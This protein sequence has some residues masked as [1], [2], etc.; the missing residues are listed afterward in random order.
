MILL[1]I[2]VLLLYLRGDKSFKEV[3]SFIVVP[4]LMFGFLSIRFVIVWVRLVMTLCLSAKA[5]SDYSLFTSFNLTKYSFLYS[6]N[7]AYSDLILD[8]KS[9]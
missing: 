6:Y 7:S 5:L 3:T 2:E 8:Y 4:E 1:I 9:L